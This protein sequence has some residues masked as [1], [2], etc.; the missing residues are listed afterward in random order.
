ML[1]ERPLTISIQDGQTAV[2][3][4]LVQLEALIQPF[5]VQVNAQDW[6]EDGI[7]GQRRN[8]TIGKGLSGAKGH[9]SLY[10]LKS[11]TMIRLEITGL[12]VALFQND[13][14]KEFDLAVLGLGKTR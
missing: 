10:P 2:D 4:Y 7:G 5:N 8:F 1:I 9:L 6:E 3:G 13:I 12:A 11:G 14:L